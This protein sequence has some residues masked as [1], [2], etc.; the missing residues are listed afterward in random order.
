MTVADI[1]RSRRRVE[2][3]FR[4]IRRRLRIKPFLGA[5]ENALKSRIR[6]AV[7]VYV[8]V[9]V[10]R[11]RPGIGESLH[12]ILLIPG[13]TIFGKTPLNQPLDTTEH[14]IQP[15]GQIK[16]LNIFDY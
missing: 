1:Y 9:A 8:I 16:Y 3:F 6:I 2:P 4:W 15:D 10:I 5:P 7:S 12:T 14:R 11:K 13:L